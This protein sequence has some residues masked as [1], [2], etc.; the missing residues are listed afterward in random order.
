MHLFSVEG[1]ST[2][3]SKEAEKI[4]MIISKLCRRKLKSVFVMSLTSQGE[5]LPQLQ[6]SH[7][8][9]SSFCW[10]FSFLTYNK[11]SM[12]D[13]EYIHLWNYELHCPSDRMV[14]GEASARAV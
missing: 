2:Q 10:L 6:L 11:A 1:R 7:N 12:R 5:E 8:D 3:A 4:L 14:E 9:H 13:L